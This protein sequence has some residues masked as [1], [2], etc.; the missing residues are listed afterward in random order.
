MY[1]LL[2]VEHGRVGEDVN[3]AQEYG[4]WQV[5]SKVTPHLLRVEVI[6]PGG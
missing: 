3:L 6:R 5:Y 4:S 2:T 1:S